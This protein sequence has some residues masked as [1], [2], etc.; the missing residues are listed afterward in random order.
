MSPPCPCP[1]CKDKIF[2]PY[3]FFFPH[4]PKFRVSVIP[5]CRIP[6]LFLELRYRTES[7]C[8]PNWRVPESVG[9]GILKRPKSGVS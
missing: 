4:R 7:L 5:E 1:I 3:P 9:T 6:N 2:P 8:E